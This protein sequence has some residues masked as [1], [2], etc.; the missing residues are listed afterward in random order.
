MQEH[1]SY[2]SDSLNLSLSRVS[3]GKPTGIEASMVERRFTGVDALESILDNRGARALRTAVV[4]VFNGQ[5]WLSMLLGHL[6]AITP[7]T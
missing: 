3:V 5:G 6:S 2:C 1:I 7:P 4:V